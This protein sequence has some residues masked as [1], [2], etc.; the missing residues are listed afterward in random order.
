MR[1]TEE[2]IFQMV[3][4]MEQLSVKIDI[5]GESIEQLN[6]KIEKHEEMYNQLNINLKQLEHTL[7]TLKEYSAQIEKI[8]N[9]NNNKISE[10]GVFNTTL[11]GKIKTIALVIS[12][13]GWLITAGLIELPF[14]H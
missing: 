10:L 2:E 7:A 8:A 1:L 14:M 12:F 13:L 3:C 6:D 9:Q 11:V 5:H 4:T